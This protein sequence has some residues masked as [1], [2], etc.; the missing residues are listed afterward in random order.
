MEN[1]KEKLK[2]IINNERLAT[3][4]SCCDLWDYSSDVEEERYCDECGSLINKDGCAVFGCNYSPVICEKCGSAPC[5][6][7]C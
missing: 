7:S 6:Q 2:A 3:I 5:D 1:N 4:S